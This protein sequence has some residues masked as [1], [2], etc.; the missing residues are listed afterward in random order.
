MPGWYPGGATHSCSKVLQPLPRLA[1]RVMHTSAFAAVLVSRFSC[2]RRRM[3]VPLRPLTGRPYAA[4]TLVGT[5]LMVD[6]TMDAGWVMQLSDTLNCRQRRS[7][8]RR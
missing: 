2:V 5:P 3:A 7:A 8:R 6:A 4:P 1:L